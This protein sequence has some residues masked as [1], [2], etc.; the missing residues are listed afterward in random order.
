MTLGKSGNWKDVV[1]AQPLRTIVPRGDSD[2][3]VIFYTSGTTGRPKGVMLGHGAVI[4]NAGIVRSLYRLSPADRTLVTGSL[5][6]IY[7]IM[8]NC[9]SSISAGVTI[10][11][12]ERFH[13]ELVLRTM[14][15]ERITLSSAFQPCT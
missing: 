7:S 5:S 14:E 11:L 1:A 13:P 3:A 8:T 2:L 15:R 10:H 9:T 6:F 4:A 12:L